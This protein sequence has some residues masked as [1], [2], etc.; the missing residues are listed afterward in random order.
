MVGLSNYSL[1][2][3]IMY[4]TQNE[5]PWGPIF[6]KCHFWPLWAYFT[7][8]SRPRAQA[9]TILESSEQS[10]LQILTLPSPWNNLLGFSRNCRLYPSHASWRNRAGSPVLWGMTYIWRRMCRKPIHT[11][12]H[13]SSTRVL[14]LLLAYYKGRGVEYEALIGLLAPL[15]GWWWLHLYTVHSLVTFSYGWAGSMS[16]GCSEIGWL[17]IRLLWSF[18]WSLGGNQGP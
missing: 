10:A 11:K 8:H 14:Y 18:S 4:W 5:A 9:C 1:D 7:P 2:V 3:Y 16:L 15:S 17:S 12:V 13:P 6:K